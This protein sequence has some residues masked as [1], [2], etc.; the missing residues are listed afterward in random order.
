M[1]LKGIY[2]Y[3]LNVSKPGQ[4]RCNSPPSSAFGIQKTEGESEQLA[5]KKKKKISHFFSQAREQVA[6]W[7]VVSFH[8][9]QDLAYCFVQF[10]FPH[11]YIIK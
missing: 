8:L 7:S 11:V 4:G 6:F 1:N 3:A 10:Y 2:F 9:V 5:L